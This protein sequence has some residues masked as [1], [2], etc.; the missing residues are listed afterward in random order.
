MTTN[1]GASELAKPAMGFGR[2][3]RE[4]DDQEAINR[5]FTPEF[6]NRLDAIVP[7]RGLAPDTIGRVVDK[8]VMQLEAQLGD[9]GV[10]IA[11]SDAA[12]DWLGKKG[13]DPAMGA[14]PLAR[15]IQ[16]YVKK[17]LAEEL[18]FG[19]LV[20]GGHVDIDMAE[21]AL[22]F[23]YGTPKDDTRNDDRPRNRGKGKPEHER[24][25]S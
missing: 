13:Y 21:D 8:F 25:K 20:K 12:R 5:A 22:V 15:V 9:R 11:L 16:E 19:R 3:V 4:G 10:T 1:A 17:P 24:V 18:L 23:R 2:D 6:R 14:R 7:F